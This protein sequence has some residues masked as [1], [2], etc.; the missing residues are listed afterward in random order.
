MKKNH[1]QKKIQNFLVWNLSKLNENFSR[2][3]KSAQDK[4][5]R[6]YEEFRNSYRKLAYKL[7]LKTAWW[8]QSTSSWIPWNRYFEQV[9]LNFSLAKKE[10]FKKQKKVKKFIYV[11]EVKIEVRYKNSDC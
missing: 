6:M 8:Q 10:Q 5:P 1:Q 2:K 3:K 7:C 11:E 9:N 4:F